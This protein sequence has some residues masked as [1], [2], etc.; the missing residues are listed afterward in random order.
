[1]GKRISYIILASL[2][3]L[4][5][6]GCWDQVQ[7]EQRGFVLGAAIDLADAP[8]NGDP[9]FALTYQIVAPGGLGGG[10]A[11]GQSGQQ[12]PFFNVTARGSTMFDITR[13][14]ASETSRTPYLGH[15]QLVIISSEVAKIPHAF[16]N[17]LDIFLRDHEMRRTVKV[18]IAADQAKG[19]LQFKSPTAK[20][21][22]A[23]IVSIA[24]NARKNIAIAPPLQIGEVHEYLLIGRSVAIPLITMSSQGK[25][26]PQIN[27]MAVYHG[28]SERMVDILSNEETKGL[29]LIKGEVQGGAI[30]VEIKGESVVYEIRRAKSSIVPKIKG[31]DDIKFNVKIETE[32]KIAES[33]ANIDYRD[34]ANVSKVEKKVE[35]EL[36]RLATV[37]LE[38]L[39]EDLQVDV[40]DFARYVKKADYQLWMS[41]KEDWDSGKNYFSQSTISIQTDTVVRSE[42][43][44][45][46]TEE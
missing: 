19:V 14:M 22:V 13:N 27:R 43:A 18:L 33:F 11:Q 32:G 8:S 42:G 41:I 28:P 36:E 30:T 24:E 25:K 1:M 15:N 46:D 10:K 37:T 4:F 7:I 39:H 2:S 17:I 9:S 21:P 29:N 31:K 23:H 40:F 35:K 20:L 3:L 44:V 38:K 6:T 26:K 34:P 12:K 16:T 5:L 45:I